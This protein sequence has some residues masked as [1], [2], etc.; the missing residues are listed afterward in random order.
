[1]ADGVVVGSALVAEAEAGGAAAFA[2]LAKGL[3]R[4][5]RLETRP[6]G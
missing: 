1:L 5:C 4:A 3:S 6:R 2:R